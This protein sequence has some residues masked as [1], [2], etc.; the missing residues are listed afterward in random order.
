MD[1]LIPGKMEFNWAG[2]QGIMDIKAMVGA[3]EQGAHG[4]MVSRRIGHHG[5]EGP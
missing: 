1:V 5:V 4:P 3:C 2:N